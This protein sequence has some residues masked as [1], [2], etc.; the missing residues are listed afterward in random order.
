MKK[1]LIISCFDW[2]DKRIKTVKE[3]MED[4][5]Y[6]VTILTSDFDHIN[7]NYTSCKYSDCTYIHVPAYQ[8]NMSLKRICS[9]LSFGRSVKKH[10]YT[11]KPD[12]IYL[13]VPPNNTAK[14]C[15]AYKKKSPQVKYILDIIDLWPESM[16]LGGLKN[17]LICKLWAKFRN[18]SVRYSDFVF[19]ECNL[20]KKKLKQCGVPKDKT[21][22]LYLFKEQEPEECALVKEKMKENVS[23]ANRHIR[24]GYVGSINNIID[25]DGISDMTAGLKDAGYSVEIHVIGDGETRQQFIEALNVSGADVRFYGKQ[26]DEKK[27]IEILSSC[28]YGINMM[29]EHVTVGLSIKSIDY[30]S[31]GLPVIN[32]IKGDTWQLIEKK[33]MGINFDGNITKLVGQI[34]KYENIGQRE[35]LRKRV[36]AG[37]RKYFTKEAFEKRL[38]EGLFR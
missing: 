16:P 25:T 9:H 19:T 33:K 35:M 2:Y 32:N 28:D 6:Q 5:Q 18:E 24:L 12:I 26:F 31:Y 27:K 11:L 34:E 4:K 17:A 10:L 37:F 7:K 14:Y 30:F 1:A 3:V 15:L 38:R 8:K 13:L 36:L 22:T 23:T 21:K 20:Y 29:K